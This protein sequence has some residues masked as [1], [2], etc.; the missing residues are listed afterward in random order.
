[1][2]QEVA[3]L[4]RD[5][6]PP[7]F[8]EADEIAGDTGGA[9]AAAADSAGAAE[10]RGGAASPVDPA[11]PDSS[12]ALHSPVGV[13]GGGVGVGVGFGGSSSLSVS[14]S[15]LPGQSSPMASSSTTAA[16]SSSHV[17][18]KQAAHPSRPCSAAGTR[19][20][21]APPSPEIDG[22]APLQLPPPA[23]LQPNSEQQQHERADEQ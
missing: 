13:P 23:A 2:S 21:S 6:A 4:L 5:H 17:P 14:A 9:A 1:V 3:Q 11:R 16:F 12:P 7:E 15:L 8:A 18:R 20:P 22:A 10:S 19:R